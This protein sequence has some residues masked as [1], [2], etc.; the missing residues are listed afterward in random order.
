MKIGH[1]AIWVSNIETA[2]EFWRAN[3][4]AEIG[5]RYESP[6][7]HGFAS[8]F[9]KLS[10]D[11][12]IELM[13]GPWIKSASNEER[14]GWAHVAINMGSR[15]LVDEIALRMKSLGKLKS[16]PR[17]TGDGFYE[18]EILDPD[19]NIIEITV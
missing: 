9:V 11:T 6:R 2:A 19:G 8:R 7:R 3:F 15:A 4:G 18:A 16:G 14:L 5:S 10:G 1:V 13:E 12:T 17:E